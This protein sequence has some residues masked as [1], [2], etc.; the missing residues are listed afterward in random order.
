MFIFVTIAKFGALTCAI[1]GLARKATTLV[2]SIHFYGHHLN[3]VQALGLAVSVGAMV[4][5]FF[6]KKGAGGGGGAGH[7][8]HGGG[9]TAAPHQ[10]DFRDAPGEERRSML[11]VAE[12][13]QD[14]GLEL[15]A[16]QK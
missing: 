1:I 9:A 8:G 2:A 14:S 16:V 10:G 7:G 15:G 13:A 4:G 6:G 3:K 5:D 12:D 11:P